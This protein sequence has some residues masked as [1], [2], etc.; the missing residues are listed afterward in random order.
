[1][2]KCFNNCISLNEI[3]WKRKGKIIICIKGNELF[4]YLWSFWGMFLVG[5]VVLFLDCF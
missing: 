3:L 4:G 5:G 2:G 1:M